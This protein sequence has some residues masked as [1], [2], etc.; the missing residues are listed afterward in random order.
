MEGGKEEAALT[1]EDETLMERRGE[2]ADGEGSFSLQKG[3]L[4]WIQG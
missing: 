4:H 2:E 3:Q 1:E